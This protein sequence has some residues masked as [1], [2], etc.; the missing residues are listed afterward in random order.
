MRKKENVKKIKE[1]VKKVFRRRNKKRKI[2]NVEHNETKLVGF[3]LV[4]VAIMVAV[5]T[6]VG[7][8]SG[9]FFTYKFV[10]EEHNKKNTDSKYIEEFE[11]AFDN[12]LDNYYEDVSKD[13]L[14]DAAIDGM[15]SILDGYT[16]YMDAEETKAFNDRMIGEYKGIGIEFVST[17]T[18]E[19]IISNV[20]ENT[21]ASVAGV[22]KGDVIVK[23]DAFDASTKSGPDIATYIR[24]EN[25]TK[26]TMIVK[27]NEEDITLQI[28][29]ALISL[30]S[31]SKKTFTSNGKKVGYINIS[32]FAN[33]TYNQF[34]TAITS[35]EKEGIESLIIDVRDNSGGYLHVAEDMIELFL[36]KDTIIYEMQDKTGIV[37]Y[38]DKTTEKR[39]Y[40][41][42]VLINGNSASA[43]EVLASALQEQYGANLVGAKSYG[44]GTVQQTNDL[45]NGGM[46]KVTTDKWL[47]SKG[48]WLDKTGLEPT[49]KVELDNNYYTN[50]SDESD[51]QLQK[52]IETVT[53]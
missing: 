22:E 50:P 52:A 34:E 44:K 1:S 37:K 36:S 17:E 28:N 4:E 3:K 12:V 21:P 38:M 25:I 8:L 29:K 48:I 16:S 14:I 35:L 6:I 30:P 7:V 46:I 19:H 32:L 45:N 5:A 42:A 49:I 39:S 51:N 43:S 15:V 40:P 11:E 13:D 47:T 31:I 33:N 9:S 18:N 26:I 10:S 24:G 2:E 27:R 41:V 20:F 53:K 23:I